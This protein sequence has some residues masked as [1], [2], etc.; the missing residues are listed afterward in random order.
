MGHVAIFAAALLW[1]SIGPVARYALEAGLAPLEIGFWRALFAGFL[2]G[3]HALARGR[4]RVH[5]RDVPAVL[6]FALFGVT[7][8]YWAFFHAVEEGGA[9]LAAVLLYTAPAW[10]AAASAVLYR[11]PV[12]RGMLLAIG[13]TMTGVLL[14]ARGG[15][16]GWSNPAA[17][18]YGLL[19][20]LAYAGYYLFGRQYFPRYDP[21]TLFTWAM[22][23]GALGLLPAGT[24]EAKPA[25]TW[26]VLAFLAAVPT[27][28][29]YLLYGVSLRYLEATRAATA[30]TIEPVAAAFLA[31]ALWGESLG[32]TG[33]AGAALVVAGVLII[34][35]A[36]RP[37][38][39]AGPA[40][41]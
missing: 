32:L 38:A 27:Y 2:F 21:A 1:A 33:Y 31:W 13:L 29:A 40:S 36:P 5:R 39:Q 20:G 15:G 37:A 4:L 22:L 11:E 8:F 41:A 7:G 34:V 25:S 9:A 18:G 10:V 30:A 17:I 26:A 14:V 6:A 24:F 16:A 23:L 28:G 35:G 19:A 3:L 12:S